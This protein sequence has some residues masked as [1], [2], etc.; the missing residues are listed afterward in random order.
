MSLL[1]THF[2]RFY[3]LL[4]LFDLACGFDV[5]SPYRII[6]K[7]LLLVA[8]LI[9]F[10]Y[11]TK[12]YNSASFYI[13][14]SALSCSLLGDIFL[15]FENNANL[16]FTLGLASFLLAHLLFTWSFL[17]KWNKKTPSNFNIITVLLLFYGIGLFFILKPNL[18]GL[19][20]PVA[21]YITGILCMG[22]SAYRRKGMVPPASFN[23]V[24]I[25]ALLFI[26]SDSILAIDKFITPVILSH[27]LIMGTYAMAQF[28]IVEGM[29]HQEYDSD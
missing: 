26:I 9:Y 4:L 22:I 8:L 24:S 10:T 3:V 18:G 5:L 23:S 29:L 15:L 13:T 1:R 7:P 20:I 28:F 11:K 14:F 6:S 12:T 2:L 21:I 16:Y 17:K 19:K 25:G 27:I